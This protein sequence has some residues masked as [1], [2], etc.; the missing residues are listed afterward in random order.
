MEYTLYP[1]NPGL[2]Y[3]AVY[4]CK[5]RFAYALVSCYLAMLEEVR[6]YAI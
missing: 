3:L 2:K 6:E 5:Q 1:K 4:T